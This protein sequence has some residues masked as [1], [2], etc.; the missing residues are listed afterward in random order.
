MFSYRTDFLAQVNNE[1]IVNWYATKTF[2][3]HCMF[4]QTVSHIM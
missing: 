3:A 1:E 2:I 4:S